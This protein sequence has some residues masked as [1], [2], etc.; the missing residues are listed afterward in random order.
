MK[1]RCYLVSPTG[2]YTTAGDETA[3][4]ALEAV[5]S[6]RRTDHITYMRARGNARAAV[7]R[8]HKQAAGNG[9]KPPQTFEHADTILPRLT[10]PNP[11]PISI[12][13]SADEVS[14]CIGPRDWQWSRVDGT[15]LGAGT[16]VG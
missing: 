16:M 7:K 5:S 2:G 3:A 6:F 10:L 8:A 9:E 15:L 1:H 14:L 13:I 11:C 4:V 12:E